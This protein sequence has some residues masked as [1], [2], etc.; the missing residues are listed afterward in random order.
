MTTAKTDVEVRAVQRGEEE[1]A[2]ALIAEIFMPSTDKSAAAAAFRAF[3]ESAPGQP[4][5]RVRGAFLEDR[6]VGTYLM[7]ERE[8]RLAG[9]TVPAGFIGVLGVQRQLRGGGIGTAM[10]N[11]SFG[12]ARQHGLALLVLHGAPRYYTP[13]G[14][15]D[16]F[17]TSEV[18]FKRTDAA[19]LGAPSLHVRAAAPGDASA[20]AALYQEA[21]RPYSGWCRRSE[22]QEEHWLRFAG[23]PRQERGELFDT[24]GPVVAVSAGGEVEGYLRQGWGPLNGF[25]CEVAA[26]GPE[27]VLSLAAYHS[28]LRGPLDGRDDTITWQLPPVSLTSELLG[29]YV[30]VT[31]G[32]A[33]RPAEGWMAAVVDTAKLTERLVALWSRSSPAESGF[34]VR[35]G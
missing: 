19:A 27:A 34:S 31:I 35:V 28:G 12:Y 18:T 1:A 10:M 20:M 11:D 25:G 24:T 3:V 26:L 2:Y 21:H 22:A 32:S 17:D 8:L 29:D 16:V 9:A 15:V 14:Y 5:D 23:K 30:P 13:F 33:H 7:D 4:A 6:C